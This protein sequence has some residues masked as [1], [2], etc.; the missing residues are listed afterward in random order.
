M[1][2]GGTIARDD[3]DGDDLVEKRG[4]AIDATGLVSGKKFV[5]LRVLL[6]EGIRSP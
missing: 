5:S 2:D 4:Y 1:R 6:D 3:G